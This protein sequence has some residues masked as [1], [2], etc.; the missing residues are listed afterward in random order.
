VVER[1]ACSGSWSEKGFCWRGVGKN[2]NL[3]K[4]FSGVH[5]KKC[6]R[7]WGSKNVVHG[8]RTRRKRGGESWEKK[9]KKSLGGLLEEAL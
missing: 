1:V 9:G 3:F 5:F 7:V 2:G 4:K 6:E 8:R